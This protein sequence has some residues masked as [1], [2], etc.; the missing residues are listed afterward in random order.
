M[1]LSDVWKFLRLSPSRPALPTDP[2]TPVTPSPGVPPVTSTPWHLDWQDVRALLY[3]GVLMFG[4]HIISQLTAYMAS[5]QA[6]EGNELTVA[7]L[8]LVLLF[9]RR[10][11][12]GA[13]VAD[14]R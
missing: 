8:G 3:A 1:K 12:G 9:L 7:A 13:P 10:L 2:A 4:P 14:K 11:I 5:L 6:T